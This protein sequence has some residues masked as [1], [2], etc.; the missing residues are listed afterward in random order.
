[1]DIVTVILLGLATWRIT[2]LLSDEDGP[3][4]IFEKMRR[5][6]GIDYDDNTGQRYGK[7]VIAK[8]V[9]CVWCLSLYVGAVWVILYLNMPEIIKIVTMPFAFS[10]IT[11]WIDKRVWLG[12]KR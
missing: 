11:V 4:L 10:T 6:I 12:H 7:N 8:Q 9:M 3:G 5:K 1:M 2:S